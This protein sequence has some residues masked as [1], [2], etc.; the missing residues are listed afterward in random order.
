MS[1]FIK[2]QRVRITN[3]HRAGEVAVI[4]YG[5]W[6]GYVLVGIEGFYGAWELEAVSD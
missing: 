2:G 1:R 3:G 5:D 6:R 4:V